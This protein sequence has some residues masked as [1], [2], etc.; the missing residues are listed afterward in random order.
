MMEAGWPMAGANRGRVII[1][2][3]CAAAGGAIARAQAPAPAPEPP[4][5]M[6]WIPG[7]FD[8]TEWVEGEWVSQ[9]EY[10]K[11]DPEKWE[12][13]PGWDEQSEKDP[14]PESDELPPAL[15]YDGPPA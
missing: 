13:E 6:V 3:I 1:A 15:P 14:L 4:S 5:G 7:W 2:A 9:E 11:A 12:P 10:D 8:G